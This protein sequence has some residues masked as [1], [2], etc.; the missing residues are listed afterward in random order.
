MTTRYTNWKFRAECMDDVLHFVSDPT[1]AKNLLEL[2][3]ERENTTFPEVDGEIKTLP[4]T[5]QSVRDTAFDL[6]D[7]HVIAQTIA[8]AHLYTGERDWDE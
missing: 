8:P 5:L 6:A 7:C 4:L 3:V 2:K 1:I